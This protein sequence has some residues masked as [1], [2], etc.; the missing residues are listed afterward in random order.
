M[1]TMITGKLCDV[2]RRAQIGIIVGTVI[3]SLIIVS[4]IIIVIVVCCR[5]KA[6][7]EKKTVERAAQII[8]VTEVNCSYTGT[9]SL[10]NMVLP[11]FSLS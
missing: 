11:C 3:G 2:F 8:G 10:C 7:A 1:M 5:Q 4:I 6:L 9:E